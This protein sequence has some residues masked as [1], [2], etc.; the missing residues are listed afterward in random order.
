MTRL[1]RIVGLAVLVTSACATERGPFTNRMSQAATPYLLRAARQPVSW[2]PWGREVF[3]LAARL[4]RPI[5]LYVG[6]D[7]C[8]WC[9]TMDREVYGDPGLGALIDSLVIPVRVDRDER[10][11]V[12]QRY[13]A[14]VLALA[15]LRGVPLTV[16]LTPDGAAFFGGTYFP[17][18]DPVTGRG[19]RQILPEVA[20]SYREGRETVQRHAMMVQQLALEGAP[21][22]HAVLAPDAIS[23]GI[24]R[25][26]E[27]L[28]ATHPGAGGERGGFV[29]TQAVTLLLA[30]FGR[31]GDTAALQVAR[32]VLDAMID[33]GAAAARATLDEPQEIVRGALARALA[34][35]FAFT[36]EPR[37]RDAGLATLRTLVAALDGTTDRPM[38]A[39]RD[40]FAI[41][42]ALEAAGPLRDS[43]SE[44]RAIS[45]LDSLK[46]RVYARGWGARHTP[47]G[48]VDGLL[49][50]QV[51]LADACITAYAVT[52]RVRYLSV[53]TSL[54]A[55]LVRD[56]AAPQGGFYD[57][58]GRDPVPAAFETRTRSA[59]DELLPGAN[60]W[61]ARVF[62]RLAAATGEPQYRRR[63][64][65]TLEAFAGTVPPQ[66]LP[67]ASFLTV[68]RDALGAH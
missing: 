11:D 28:T 31:T 20:R 56:F 41:A 48:S 14:E 27:E 16:F 39:D 7:D 66:G 58:A 62:L 5:L 33:S 17:A 13:G 45:A 1:P 34:L 60:A 67:A 40:G 65:A 46:R 61:A 10:P 12:A 24:V 68:A 29:Q 59:T 19:L 35:A 42:A 3:A 23:A 8:R 38:F 15:G 52:G 43:V 47:A 44:R 37:Y 57:T 30:E 22:I 4:D 50:D 54:A 21:A 25:I 63:A 6:A 32:N 26:R 49:Q 2:Q 18:D 9:L 53:A 64:E 51:Q 55:I 36:G